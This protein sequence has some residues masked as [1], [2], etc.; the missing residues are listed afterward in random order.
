[1]MELPDRNVAVL[2]ENNHQDLE[3]WYP[4]FRFQ[5]AGATVSVIGP[6]AQKYLSKLGYPVVA[7]QAA[8]SVKDRLFDALIVP[9]GYA[10]DLMRLND[11]MVAMVRNHVRNGRVV[12]AICHGSWM[13]ASAD[14]IRG[15][16][17]TGAPSIKDDLVNAG[18]RF[19]DKEVICDG[20]IVTSRKPGDLPAFCRAIVQILSVSD[21]KAV[22]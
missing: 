1:M 19:E 8:D 10:P 6:Q 11:A 17:V 22:A 3:V 12:A 21:A 14:V 4:I 9:G 18:G 16:N 2:V 5:E 13:L 7:D 15:K 20:C